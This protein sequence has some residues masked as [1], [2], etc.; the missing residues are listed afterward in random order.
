MRVN[1]HRLGVYFRNWGQH[2][3]DAKKVFFHYKKNVKKDIPNLTSSY[4]ASLYFFEK[5]IKKKKVIIKGSIPKV[6][7]VLT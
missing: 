3:K 7:S 6:D 2:L 4:E 5:K 1:L